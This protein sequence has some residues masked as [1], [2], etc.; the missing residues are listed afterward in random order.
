MVTIDVAGPGNP[1]T[2]DM[3]P[4]DLR[5]MIG[6]VIDECVQLRGEGGYTTNG[7]T[8]IFQWFLHWEQ[9]EDQS[10]V[11]VVGEGV[12]PLWL[13]RYRKQQQSVL[14]LVLSTPVLTLSATC[15]PLNYR[16]NSLSLCFNEH[17]YEAL[18]LSKPSAADWVS[19]L[20]V[21]VTSLTVGKFDM[22]GDFDPVMPRVISEALDRIGTERN[23]MDSTSYAVLMGNAHY[24][25]SKAILM[26]EGKWLGPWWKTNL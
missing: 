5:G 3:K 7:L 10:R 12:M 4:N 21:S 20:T 6:Y 1:K 19:F 11:G 18:Q 8:N 24:F 25:T 15:I 23:D 13:D 16:C 17:P 9:N 22:P 2:I 26:R 14:V